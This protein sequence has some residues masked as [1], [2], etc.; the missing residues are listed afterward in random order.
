[1]SGHPPVLPSSPR[2][3]IDAS[4]LP[5]EGFGTKNTAWWG[6]VA[7]MVVEGT[8]LLFCLAA[9]FYLRRNFDSYPPA[10][11]AQPSLLVP[12]ISVLVM[13][14]SLFLVK[15]ADRAAKEHDRRRVLLTL[16]ALLAFEVVIMVLRAFELDA[17]QVRWD[18]NAYGSAVWF[19]L[20]F[21]TTLLLVDFA[22]S[23]V[24]FLIFARNKNE[25]KHWPDVADDV[26][27][28]M[29]VVLIWIPIYL[30]VYVWPQ[31]AG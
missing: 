29:F 14:A 22:E 11:I 20:G 25:P 17:L 1:M 6:T 24:I 4:V 10:G 26:F 13:L 23:L 30:A 2:G 15:H 28:W 8:A 5:S 19:T 21:H 7:F 3:G 16:S 9:Y 31:F 12:T 18:T 27:Y